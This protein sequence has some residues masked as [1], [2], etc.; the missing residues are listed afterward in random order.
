[1]NYHYDTKEEAQRVALARD[2]FSARLLTNR[3]FEEA[4]ALT[5][6]IEREIRRSG[7]FKEKLGDYAHAFARPRSQPFDSK[8]AEGILREL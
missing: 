7:S 2:S 1:M 3:Q 5:H 4:M 6:V 8:N